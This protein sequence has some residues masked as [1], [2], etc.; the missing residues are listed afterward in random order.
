MGERAWALQV[1]YKSSRGP[2]SWVGGNGLGIEEWNRRKLW[3]DRDEVAGEAHRWRA[4]QWQ[5]K[6]VRVTRR[7]MVM[8]GEDR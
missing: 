2:W 7:P 8:K 3:G 1:R 4:C 6:V 5:T